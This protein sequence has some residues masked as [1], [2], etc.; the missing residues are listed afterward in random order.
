MVKLVETGGTAASFRPFA[1]IAFDASSRLTFKRLRRPTRLPTIAS[2][3]GLGW[4]LERLNSL[5]GGR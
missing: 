2:S 1:P 3:A 5:F 4:Y